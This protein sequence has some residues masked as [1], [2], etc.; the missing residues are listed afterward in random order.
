MIV[1]VI[2]AGGSGT[3]LWP[4]SRAGYPKQFLPLTGNQTMLQET[5]TRLHQLSLSES[6]TIC[7]EEH[8][9]FVAEQLREVDSL[10]KIILEPD[11]RNTA[12]AIALAALSVDQDP[13]LLV[14]AADHVIE[15]VDAFTA[16]VQ[17][18]IPLAKDDQLVTFGV[19]PAQP[20]V[21][22]GYIEAGDKVGG[23]YKVISFKEKPSL[24]TATDYLKAGGFYWNSGMFLF[25]AS[26]YLEELK[27]F[28]PDIYQACLNS[29]ANTSTDLDFIRI[30]HEA[31]KGCP[32]E[33]IDYAVMENT[34]DAVVVP[35]DAGWND[36]GSWSS[37]WEVCDK[38]DLGNVVVG[39]AMLH[40]TKGS[41]IRS[42]NQ[43]TVA[44]GV[45]DLIVVCTKD[46]IMVA[47][48]DRVQDAKLMAQQLKSNGRSEWEFHRE[49]YRPWGKYDS[50]DSG[51]GYKVKRITVSPGAKLSVQK[52][53]HRAEHW[54]VVSGTAEVT[55]GDET[56]LLRENESTYVS[57]GTVHAV[58]NP[59][60][61]PLEIIEIQTGSYLGEDDIVRYGDVYS[62]T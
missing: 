8:R 4:L 53:R 55:N 22:Y 9:F 30:D 50:I 24:Q 46:A 38:D 47:H 28:R 60:K 58:G 34:S 25:K 6:I 54:V 37:L 7:N 26:R 40:D 56:F 5:I 2:M 15:N 11:G 21:G 12:P 39:D 13:L 32:S 19:V 42:D 14:L 3:R 45:E 18:A 17:Q 51:D 23:G 1:P 36:I 31:F 27:T 20:H 62:R 10:G 49:V 44:I 43:L 59:G 16:A 61:T 35:L 41:Y 52:H 57:T 48:K 29:V 33:S